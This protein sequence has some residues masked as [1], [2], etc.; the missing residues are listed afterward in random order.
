[1]KTGVYEQILCEVVTSLHEYITTMEVVSDSGLSSPLNTVQQGPA[2]SALWPV[3]IGDT[4]WE[5]EC[6]Q[7]ANA[8]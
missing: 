4:R 1:M 7:V 8:E 6:T 2:K 5:P 3:L